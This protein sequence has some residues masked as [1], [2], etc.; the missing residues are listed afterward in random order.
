MKPRYAELLLF[1]TAVVW[2]FGFVGAHMALE[3][4]ITPLQMLVG[5]F[6]TASILIGCIFPREARRVTL[7]FAAA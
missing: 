6:M 4:D 1:L 3:A 5:R 7:P 2:G